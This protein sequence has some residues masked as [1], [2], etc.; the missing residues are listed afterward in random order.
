MTGPVAA[1]EPSQWLLESLSLIPRDGT[2]LDVACGRGRHALLLARSGWRVHAIDRDLAALEDLRATAEAAELPITIEVLDLEDGTPSLGHQ[3]YG[4][5]VV[6]NYLHRPLL[7]AIIDAIAPGGV[8]VYETFTAGQAE[9]GHPKNPA[10]LL[11]QGELPQLVKPLEILRS[12]EGEFDG[13]LLASIVAAR[14]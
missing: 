12:R 9:R 13:N 14:R 3:R 4:G 1:P 11:Q 8:L 6:F 10:F 7:P 5:V 2:V